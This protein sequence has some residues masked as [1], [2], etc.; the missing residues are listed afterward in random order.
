ML[1]GLESPAPPIKVE[2]WLRGQPLASL[3]PGTVYVV[4]FWATWCGPC[5]AALPDLVQL[6]EKYKNSGIEVLG[7]AAHER[8]Q[9]AEEARNKLDAWLTEKVPNLNYRMGFDSTGEMEK[10]WLDPSFSV[11]IP[12]SFV[13]DR[14]GR[15]AFVGFPT[16][17]DNVLP[18]I[19]IGSWRTSDEAK[20]A[21]TERI[22]ENERVM[23]EWRAQEARTE[24][25]SPNLR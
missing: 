10:L 16:E 22:A 25:L 21:E 2:N 7:V 19:L 15:I 20:A 9:T 18:K 24:P 1:L 23:C 14:D 12:T 17:L 8:A 4:E 6:Q 11:G 5:V 3:Q 13:V